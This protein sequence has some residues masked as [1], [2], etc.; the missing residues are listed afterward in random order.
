MRA[1]F[2]LRLLQVNSADEAD[3][4]AGA[5]DLIGRSVRLE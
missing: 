3:G 5:V 2:A 1:D 4:D